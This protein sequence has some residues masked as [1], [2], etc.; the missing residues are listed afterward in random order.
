MELIIKNLKHWRD[1][2]KDSLKENHTDESLFLKKEI[3]K[4]IYCLELCSK[5]NINK[6][7]I[8]AIVVLPESKTGYSEYRILDDCEVDNRNLWREISRATSGD[9]VI[10]LK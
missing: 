4:A 8:E 3:E 5:H 2:V 7:N 1:E 9:F 10:K 6:N